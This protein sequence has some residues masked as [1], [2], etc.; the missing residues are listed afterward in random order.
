MAKLVTDRESSAESVAA[1][2]TH[3][4]KIQ[5]A[6]EA[7]FHKHLRAKEKMPDLGLALALVARALRA[8]SESLIEASRLNDAAPREARDGATAE[9]VSL[10]VGIRSTIDTR[11]GRPATSPPAPR[12]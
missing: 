9:L 8:T 4:D 7:Q 6:F 3:S 5:Q 12:K 11:P 2:D 10:T 1:A